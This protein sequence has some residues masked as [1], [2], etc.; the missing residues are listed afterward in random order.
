VATIAIAVLVIAG[1]ASTTVPLERIGQADK[2]ITEARQSSAAVNAPVEL[3]TAEDKVTEARNAMIAEDHDRATRLAEQAQV[4]AD[5][6]RVRAAS[7]KSK[8]TAQD[9]R[10][11]IQN[12]RREL[13]R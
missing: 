11:N 1:C 7:E 13:E 4:D 9:M 3:K 6:A 5:Y 12:L 10:A 2:A 8:K